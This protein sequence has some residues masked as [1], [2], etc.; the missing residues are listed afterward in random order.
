MGNLL[1]LLI[2]LEKDRW[3]H[4]CLSTGLMSAGQRL[5]NNGK[6]SPSTDKLTYILSGRDR[7]PGLIV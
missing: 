3:K 2:L 7:L 5:G 4:K 6:I 1:I